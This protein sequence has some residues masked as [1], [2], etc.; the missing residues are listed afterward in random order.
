MKGYEVS[1]GRYVP[2]DPGGARGRST[3]KATRTIEIQRLRR[4][5]RDRP[6]LLRADLLPRARAAARRRPTRLLLEAMRASGRSGSR[7]SSCE[8]S[9]SLCCVRPMEDA[10]ALSTMNLRRR[11]RSRSR[12]STCRATPS[13]APREL[14]MAEQLVASLTTPFDP[15]RYHGRAPGEGPRA[16]REKAAGRDDRARG[17][18]SDPA[19]VVS[20]ADA[21]AASLAAARRPRAGES[22]HEPGRQALAPRLPARPQRAAAHAAGAAAEKGS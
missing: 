14:E 19:K 21:L 11:G 4:A 3:R 7:A 9:K 12:R 22:T 6:D 5:R 15:E 13:R 17:R 2:L 10:L 1:K 20:L 16:G 18:T 8:R